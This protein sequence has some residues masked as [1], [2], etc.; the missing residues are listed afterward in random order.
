MTS[1]STNFVKSI[2]KFN[3]SMWSASFWLI[4]RKQSKKEFDFTVLR[5]EIDTKLQQRFIKYLKEQLQTKD[6]HI[7]EYDF[8]N[9]DGED[10]LFTIDADATSF[11]YVETAIENAFENLRVKKYDELLNSWAYVVLFERGEE[12]IYAWRK[13]NSMT[14]PKN[15]KTKKAIFFQNERLIDVDEE[16]VFL[17]DPRFDFFVYKKQVLITNKQA[18][19]SSMNFREGM[20]EKADLVY[21]DF[22]KLKFLSNVGLIRQFVGN[23]LHHIRKLCSIHKSGYYKQKEFILRLIE[24]CL[25]EG[26]NLKVVDKQIVVEENTIELLLKLL[27]NDR[28]KSPINYEYFD[29]AAKA[30]VN[31]KIK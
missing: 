8:N 5:A 16:K 15:I 14:Q 17:I 6:F 30:P 3:F 23:N 26:W 12:K 21:T 9:A 7:A 22:E 29:S 19:E 28:L 1:G 10:T 24:V 11:S 4:K 25:E 27:N 18:F 2:K 13:I 20:K 31:K